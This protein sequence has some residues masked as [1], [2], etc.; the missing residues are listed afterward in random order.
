MIRVHNGKRRVFQN[1]FPKNAMMLRK[2]LLVSF[3]QSYWFQKTGCSLLVL[4]YINTIRIQAA[5][6]YLKKTGDTW[7]DRLD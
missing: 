6:D 3:V 5:C 7:Y 1:I 2:E 4:Q